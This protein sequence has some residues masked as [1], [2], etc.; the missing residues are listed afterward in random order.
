[1]TRLWVSVAVS[2][3]ASG[4]CAARTVTVWAVF[5]FPPVKVRVPGDTVTSPLSLDT[6]TGTSPDG[7]V[8][9]T[10]V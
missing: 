7:L 1:M 3:A 10:T 9:S 8:F 5:Q 6:L 2:A 4:S